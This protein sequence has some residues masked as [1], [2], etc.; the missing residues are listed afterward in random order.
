LLI[1][2]FALDLAI[3]IPFNRQSM[4]MDVGFLTCSVILGFLSWATLRE[5][6]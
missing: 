6:H 2:V 4:V 3:K 5:G 1:L